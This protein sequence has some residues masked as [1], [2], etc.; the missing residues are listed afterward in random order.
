MKV[1]TVDDRG[2]GGSKVA[3]IRQIVRL[4]EILQKW[5]NVALGLRPSAPRSGDGPRSG[6]GAV[7]KGHNFASACE[8]NAPVMDQQHALSRGCGMAFSS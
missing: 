3:G 5:Q 6:W 2:S 4:K 7:S 8:Q 1:L